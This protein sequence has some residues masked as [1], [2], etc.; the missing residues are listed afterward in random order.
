MYYYLYRVTN[1]SDS[2]YV[3]HYTYVYII[4]VLSE[5]LFL[6]VKNSKNHGMQKLKAHN[7]RYDIIKDKFVKKICLFIKIFL[8]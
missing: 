2:L 5:K 4:R 7:I 6:S 8:S 3:H 1:F